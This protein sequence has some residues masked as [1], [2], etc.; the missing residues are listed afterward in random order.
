MNEHHNIKNRSG[1]P[2]ALLERVEGFADAAALQSRTTADGKLRL[3][4]IDGVKYRLARPVSHHHGHLTEVFRTDWGL[5]ELP[6][7]QVNLT[8]TFPGR[9]RAWG[10][11]RQTVD[12]LFAASGAFCIVCYDGRQNSPTFGCVNEF[13]LGERNQGLVVIPPGVYHGWKNI[14]YDEGAIVSMPSRLYDHNGPDRWELP[15]D[16]DAARAAIPYR[17]T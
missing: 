8:T 14:G 4:P 16:S 9:I 12:R 5:T 10:I 3:Q 7:V 2:A 17:W 1:A 11:H 6:L 13:V 15:W